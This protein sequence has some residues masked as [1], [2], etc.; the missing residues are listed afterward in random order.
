MKIIYNMNLRNQKSKKQKT[1]KRIEF[2]TV[3]EG[4][5]ERLSLSL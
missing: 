5:G 2:A 3:F 4:P 1:T